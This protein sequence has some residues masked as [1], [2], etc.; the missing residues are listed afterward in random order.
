MYGLLKHIEMQRLR[1]IKI[2][3]HN[4]DNL[5]HRFVLKYSVLETFFFVCVFVD[6]QL[7]VVCH[8]TK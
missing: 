7:H 2:I 8:A 4:M 5:L 6:V 3:K 1:N